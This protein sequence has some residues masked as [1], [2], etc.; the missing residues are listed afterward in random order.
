MAL[1]SGWQEAGG[2][3]QSLGRGQSLEPGRLNK[4]VKKD[5]EAPVW[6]PAQ[7]RFRVKDDVLLCDNDECL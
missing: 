6:K 5:E 3:P 1:C 4:K 7:L 2:S